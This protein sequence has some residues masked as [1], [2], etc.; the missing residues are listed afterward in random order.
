MQSAEELARLDAAPWQAGA[1]D[2]ITWSELPAGQTYI[3][4]AEILWI[5]TGQA[6]GQG[7]VKSRDGG[8]WAWSKAN[9]AW[10]PIGS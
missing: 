4:D 7:Y 9:R 6:T 5:G 2:G 10:L 3:G 8:L 1:A